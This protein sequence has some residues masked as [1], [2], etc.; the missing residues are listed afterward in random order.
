MKR[1]SAHSQPPINRQF[2]RM[3]HANG[4]AW[5][6]LRPERIYCRKYRKENV[7]PAQICSPIQF[8]HLDFLFFHFLIYFFLPSN[9]IN[10]I[11]IEFRNSK[12]NNARIVLLQLTSSVVRWPS[13]GQIKVPFFPFQC[14]NAFSI[15]RIAI[16][17]PRSDLMAINLFWSFNQ[18]G[19]EQSGGQSPASFAHS[20]N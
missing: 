5:T 16:A 7:S 13:T 1:S 19:V 14:Y 12:W 2:T 15:H 6:V 9:S 4:M 18:P 3:P 17:R 11:R 10:K 8:F 20:N